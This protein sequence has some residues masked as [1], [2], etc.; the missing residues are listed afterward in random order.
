MSDSSTPLD[1]K[2]QFWIAFTF[3]WTSGLFT[4]LL[5]SP[6][7]IADAVEQSRLTDGGELTVGKVVGHKIE[8]RSNRDRYIATIE[9]TVNT[10]QFQIQVQGSGAST[11]RLPYGTPI[12]VVYLPSNP[13]FSR[14]DISG[15]TSGG[16]PGWT[17]LIALWSVTVASMVGAYATRRRENRLSA[18]RSAA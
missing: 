10:K 11:Q 13:I 7:F 8:R 18:Q 5:W 16:G 15:A 14:V 12:D 1:K 4:T 6:V 3:L 9:Y 17:G 2:R